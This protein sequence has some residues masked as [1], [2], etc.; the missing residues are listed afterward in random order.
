MEVRRI[1]DALKVRASHQ[2]D[3]IAHDDTRRQ[4]TFCE[5]DS[6]SD[7]VGGGLA[8]AGLVPGDRVFLPISNM[9]AIDMAIAVFAV[10]RAGGIA[11]SEERRVG[12]ECRPRGRLEA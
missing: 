10:F 12:K 7:E 6:A 2:K 11:R 4:M 1:S 8:A 9:H 5:W 3:D